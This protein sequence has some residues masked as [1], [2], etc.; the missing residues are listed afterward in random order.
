V[1]LIEADAPYRASVFQ[2]G[3]DV[4]ENGAGVCCA[5]NCARTQA[6]LVGRAEGVPYVVRDIGTMAYALEL[7]G[8]QKMGDVVVVDASGEEV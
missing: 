2:R 4:R 8:S 5:Q 6:V 3:R 7:T 1:D